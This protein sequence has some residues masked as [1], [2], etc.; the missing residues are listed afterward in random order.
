MIKLKYEIDLSKLEIYQKREMQQELEAELEV[1]KSR[2]KQLKIEIKR[3]EL[4]ATDLQ[5]TLKQKEDELDQL[6]EIMRDRDQVI[7]ELERAIGDRAAVQTIVSK[8]TSK[9]RQVDNWYRPI[10]GDL[11]DELIAKYFN[12]LRYPLP[13]KRLGDGF[14]MFGTKKIYVKLL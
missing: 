12:A 8:N 1:E 7:E 13:I 2:Y 5:A 10:K 11:V 6:E 14:Y 4:R 9:K 3:L